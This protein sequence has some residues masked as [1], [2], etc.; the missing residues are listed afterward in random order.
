MTAGFSVTQSRALALIPKFAG[1]VSMLFSLLIVVTVFRDRHKRNRTYHRL[2]CGISFVDISSSFWLGLSTWPIPR[3]SGVLWAVGNE[4]TCSLQGF[5]T[6]FGVASSFYNASLALYFLLVIKYG[7]QESR[8]RQIEPFLHA[9]P[10]LWGLG[11]AATG[12][13]MGVLGNATLWCW[14]N[15]QY[16]MHRWVMFYGPLWLMICLV[17]LSSVLIYMHVRRLASVSQRFSSRQMRQFSASSIPVGP[18][19]EHRS[20]MVRSD[21]DRDQVLSGLSSGMHEE[22]EITQTTISAEVPQGVSSEG[23]RSSPNET[24]TLDSSLSIDIEVERRS[25]DTTSLSPCLGSENSVTESRVQFTAQQDRM[26]PIADDSQRKQ[27]RLIGS[28]VLS[29]VLSQGKRERFKIE[30]YQRR[31]RE[32]A[33][34]C[35]WYAGAFYINWIALSVIILGA[36]MLLSALHLRGYASLTLFAFCLNFQLTR[37]LS[38]TRGELYYPLLLIAVITTPLQGLPNVVVYLGPKY[39]K[40]KRQSPNA[41]FWRLVKGSVAR[42]KRGVPSLMPLDDDVPEQDGDQS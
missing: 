16:E 34:Q 3:D 32:V 28:S 13:G 18:G 23:Q 30:S 36:A 17:T 19:K 20:I 31:T 14:I 10:L 2:L 7:W 38:A 39:R 5:F 29:R 9:I 27:N 22:G 6:Q 41:G 8:I 21:E 24:K 26:A 1:T 15:A 37:L 40:L 42:E 33:S 35:F 12:L 11:T 25:D 4:R